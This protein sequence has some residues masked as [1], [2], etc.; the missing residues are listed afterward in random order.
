MFDIDEFVDIIKSTSGENLFNP[1]TDSCIH[2]SEGACGLR[3]KNLRTY[4]GVVGRTDTI[5]IGEAPGYLGCRRT[6]IPFT[7]NDHLDKVAKIYNLN[8]LN[9]TTKT[10]KE[11]ENSSLYMWRTIEK[12]PEP[13]F[14]W[15]IIPLHPHDEDNQFSNRTPNK[16]D[17]LSTKKVIS[18]LLK[19]G[20]FERII[21]VGRV[22]ETH[23]INMGY[24][25]LYVRHPSFG[26]SK[27]FEQQILQLFEKPTSMQTT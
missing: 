16:M 26:G 13:P 19:N 14:V 15:N 18:Y 24:R 27:I 5:V 10:G 25:C 23:L 11:K 2:D 12:L 9:R 4:L 8:N 3:E 6:G 22:A 7:D 20:D 1:Y 17:Y 21:A